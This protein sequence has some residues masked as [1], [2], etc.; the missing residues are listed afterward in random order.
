MHSLVDHTELSDNKDVVGWAAIV[1][2][3]MS[4][5]SLARNILKQKDGVRKLVSQK[6]YLCNVHKFTEIFNVSDLWQLNLEITI[7]NNARFTIK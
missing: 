3:N 6:K 5:C 2:A 1:I 7:I 4:K